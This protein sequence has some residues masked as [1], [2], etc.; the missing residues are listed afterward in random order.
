METGPG[1]PNWVPIEQ[2]SAFMLQAVLAQEDAGFFRHHGFA[3]AE[4]EKALAANLEA[5]RFVKGA[6]TISMQLV[7]NLILHRKKTLA[8]KFQEVI[9]TWWV[10]EALDKKDILELY[11]NVIEF[12]PDIYGIKAAA[13]HYFGRY[14]A[15][16]SPAESVF[17]STILPNPKG[18]YPQY[19]RESLSPRWRTRMQ[20]RLEH[21]YARGRIDQAAL[22]YGLK[23]LENFHFFKGNGMAGA[24]VIEGNPTP[25]PYQNGEDY[26]TYKGVSE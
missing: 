26:E 5:G 4:I 1:T 3:V 13:R 7:K 18:Y 22:S 19:E 21:M 11:L 25:L 12:G 9:L 15:E 24:R 17:L 23:E 6:S 20:R 14:P 10:E 16:L 8:R 2:I